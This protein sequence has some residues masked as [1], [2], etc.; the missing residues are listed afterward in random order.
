[1]KVLFW[2]DGFW[3]R[4]GGIETQAF[5][6]IKGMQQRGH[7]YRVIAQQDSPKDKEYEIYEGIPIQRFTFSIIQQDLS[8]LRRIQNEVQGLMNE[9]QPHIIHL[10][11][12]AG[13]GVLVF[14]LLKEM[15]RCPIILTL[16]APFFYESQNPFLAQ[17][18]AVS[19]HIFCVSQWVLDETKKLIPTA[20]PK[21]QLIYNGLSLPSHLP[22]ALPFSPPVLLLLGRLS[23]EKG[24]E[25]AIQAFSY[26]KN[27]GSSARLIIAGG[28]Q[29][30]PL[31]ES[32]VHQLKLQD[33]VH[34]TGELEREQGRM[35]I[36]QATLMLVPSYFESFGLV[37]LEAMHMQRPVIASRIGG[38]QEVILDNQTGFL[39]PPH[40]PLALYHKIEL[41]LN[42]PD[43]AIE[44]GLQ[45]YK[46]ATE[47]FTLK[48]NMMAYEEALCRL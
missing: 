5:E 20:L 38:L 7:D 4:T 26:L 25:T 46:R 31:L 19:C 37:A 16:H 8:Y 27:S 30:R 29:E 44:M 21:L 28:G 34:F 39:V 15:F 45:G 22:T 35:W 40:D 18:A 6:F 48:Q 23:P 10:N 14:L 2:T 17:I 12:C 32:L 11:A 42:Q 33:A 1:M 9:F 13:L 41:L 43:R 24:F 47:H 3:P 36:N